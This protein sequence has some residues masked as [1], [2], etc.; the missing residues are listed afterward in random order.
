MSIFQRLLLWRIGDMAVTPINYL[1]VAAFLSCTGVYAD[2]QASDLHSAESQLTPSTGSVV[3]QVRTIRASERNNKAK[4]SQA[5]VVDPRLEDI[6]EKL[7]KL[8]FRKFQQIASQEQNLA[9]RQKETLNLG[10]GQTLTLR[11][12]YIEDH[13]IGMWLKWLDR[14][15]AALLDTRMHFD[16]GENLLTG[17]DGNADDGVVL[18]IGVKRDL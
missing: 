1:I 13:R 4:T 2:P 14:S 7:A 9:F 15:G 6:H 8:G 11:P 17:T 5:L 12:L 18:A 16:C 3:V 10:D